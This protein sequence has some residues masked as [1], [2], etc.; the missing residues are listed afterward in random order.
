MS[1]FNQ[2]RLTNETFKLDVDRMRRGW[3][4]DKYFANI[5]RMLAGVGESGG[6]QG[7]YA[8]D[9]GRDPNGLD[10]GDIEVEMQ[11]FTRRSGKTVVVGV[12]KALSMLRHCTGY[13]D[14]QGDWIATWAKLKV[15]AV[16]DG[17]IAHYE[18][19]PL[20][21]QRHVYRVAIREVM[22]N[23]RHRLVFSRVE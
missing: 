2:E 16:H 18:G 3:Y 13:F 22:A 5:L 17:A 23:G 14:D 15:E 20:Q 21:V 8:R 1:L 11:F 9:I 7:A 6:Y 12:D 10:V 19:D 4:S